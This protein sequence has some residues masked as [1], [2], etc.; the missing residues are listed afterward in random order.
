MSRDVTDDVTA[1]VTD[2]DSEVKPA[3]RPVVSQVDVCT[4][5]AVHAT[6]NERIRHSR[7]GV[8]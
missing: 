3:P 8:C 4:H 6:N 1:D 5:N 7:V 2:G